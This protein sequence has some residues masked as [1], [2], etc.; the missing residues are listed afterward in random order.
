MTSSKLPHKGDSVSFRSPLA[1]AIVFGGSLGLLY[2]A[3]QHLETRMSS[4]LSV[5]A[6]VNGA[7][8][9]LKAPEKGIVSPATVA[10]GDRIRR[11]Q[12]LFTITNERASEVQFQAVAGRMKQQQQE[13]LAVRAKL[14]RKQD[15][16]SQVEQ[17]AAQQIELEGSEV[18]SQIYQLE[19]EL[20]GAKSR[21]KLAKLNYGRLVKLQQQGAIPAIDVEIA[22]S[23]QEQRA[24]D[25]ASLANRIRTQ[26]VNQVAIAEGLTLGRTRS[27]YDPTIRQQELSLEI[28]AL[29][30]E[31]TVL[32]QR[33][34]NTQAEALKVQE[35][36]RRQQ[37]TE[38]EAPASG[39]LWEMLAQP[40]QF[41]QQGETLGKMMDCEQRWV[42]A[43]VD[44]NALGSLKI[45]TPASVQLHGAEEVVLQGSVSMVRGGV[46][47]LAAGEDVMA[48]LQRN[49]P[50][51]TQVRIK[52]QTPTAAALV[53]HNPS[54]E[55]ANLCYIGYTGRVTF[56]RQGGAPA[57]SSLWS[58]LRNMAGRLAS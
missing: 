24:S 48:P 6:V 15:M 7:L 47:R 12:A 46:G 41:V 11:E 57:Q 17:D 40:G 56:D 3:Y 32:E 31:A 34:Q 52:L 5:D 21:L 36:T 25:V 2:L 4:V 23:E 10:T 42:D 54:I 16:L 26:R 53:A 28:S 22:Q 9:E 55:A 33:I 51:H 29:E 43:V 27:N 44:E 30:Q 19:S 39:V 50:R 18:T 35:D 13:L 8:V 20:Q 45:G 58:K 14:G 37:L 49:L 38:V 1:N